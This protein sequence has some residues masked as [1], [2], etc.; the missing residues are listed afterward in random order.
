MSEQQL[1]TKLD[2]MIADLK[3]SITIISSSFAGNVNCF[4]LDK[5]NHM[6]NLKG[7]DIELVYKD[8]DD[9]C[10]LFWCKA[11]EDV[12]IPTHYHRYSKEI[13]VVQKGRITCLEDNTVLKEGDVKIHPKGEIHT[14]HALSGSEFY[15]LFMPAIETVCEEVN[16]RQ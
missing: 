10:T 12:L 14:Y 5:E 3:S 15:C 7:M 16:G 8:P 1:M 6:V 11:S 9:F 2:K 13:L 4:E